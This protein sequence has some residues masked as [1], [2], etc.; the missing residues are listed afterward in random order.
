MVGP[1]LVRVVDEVDYLLLDGQALLLGSLL[2]DHALLLLLQF[3]TG[4]HWSIIIIVWGE[5]VH[6][7]HSG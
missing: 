4:L 2:L 6:I 1:R 7:V 5:I 3:K